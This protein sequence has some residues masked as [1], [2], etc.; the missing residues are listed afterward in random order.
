MNFIY[1]KTRSK[2]TEHAQ[3]SQGENVEAVAR[4][5]FRFSVRAK[6]DAGS[7]TSR[8][9]EKKTRRRYVREDPQRP[10]LALYGA[11]PE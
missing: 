9:R 7:N 11:A 4:L 1:K 10:R 5:R 2:S 3:I 6:A 8:D